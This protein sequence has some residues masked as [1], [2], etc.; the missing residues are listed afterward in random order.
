VGTETDID[1]I[2]DTT[3]ELGIEA[4]AV[5]GIEDGTFDQLMTRIDG[6]EATVTMTLDGRLLANEIG[7]ITGLDQL[8]GTETETEV[9]SAGRATVGPLMHLLASVTGIM[10]YDEG[11]V[12]ESGKN[13]GTD[14]VYERYPVWK[15]AVGA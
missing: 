15:A 6:E 14:G 3:F 13:D 2:T 10:T 9:I 4:M 12:T 1:V 8:V 7:I 5:V 11:T